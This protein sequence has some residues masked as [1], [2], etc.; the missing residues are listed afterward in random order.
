MRFIYDRQK[1][2]VVFKDKEYTYKEII[3]SLKYYAT[4][5]SLNEDDKVVVTME[6]RPEMIC[7]IF[8]VWENKGTTVVL[9]S[10]Y[11]AEQFAYAFQ[12]SKPKYIITSQKIVN[13]V[14]E[15]VEKSGLDIKIF[16]V[17]EITT[18]E[19]FEPNNYEV[20][21]ENLEKVA[22]LLYTSGTTGN[23]KG[24]MLTFNNLQSNINAVKEIELV[25]D[26]DRVLA[27]LP[28]HHILPLNLSM[29]MPVYFGTFLAILDELSSDALKSILKKQRISVIIGVPRVW[30][31]LHKGIMN[32]IN[33]NWAAKNLFTL[34]E[35]VG[36]EAFSKKVFK[37]VSDELGGNMRVLVS[38][39]A[40]LSPEIVRDFETL[41]LPIIEGYGLTE[42]SPIIAF[43]QPGKVR[44]GSVG[45][46][47]PNVE[48]KIGSDE[49]ILVKGANVMKGYYNNPKATSEAIDSD[50]WFHTGDLGKLEDNYLYIT[51]RKKEMIVL[52]NG[53][54][55][56][57]GDI[58]TE[59][60]KKTDLIKEIAVMEY[61]NHLMAI[62]YPD[63]DLLRQRKIANIKETLKWEIIDSYNVTAPAYRKIL[64]IKITKEELPKTKLGKIRRFMLKD[65]LKNMASDEEDKQT[66]K[67]KIEIPTE[68]RY[69]YDTLK[70]YLEKTYDVEVEPESHLELDLGLDSLD[71]VE[72]LS[73][74]EGN[75]G[76]KITEE[77]FSDLKNVLE[78]A[79]YIKE[80]GGSYHQEGTN[81]H[82]ILQE[83][84][85]VKL[86][87]SSV[88]SNVVKY[89]FKPVF[90][91][92]FHLKKEDL[93]KIPSKPAIY[94]GNHQ[95]FVD[96]FA[97]NE[98]I[99]TSK[100]K[101]T[102]YIAVATHF[103][104]PV[105]RYLANK[106]NVV[107]IDINKNLKD[108]LQISA[109]ILREGK[110]L[111]IFPEG[112]RTRDGELQ[113]FKKTF[114]ILSKE[115]NVPVV[116]FGIKGAY[117]AMPYG[118]KFPK[119]SPITVKFFDTIN[120]ENMTVEE[121]VKT[122]RETIKNWLD[123]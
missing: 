3:K 57:P 68:I 103:D 51:G 89:L 98:C 35:K 38:G 22:L 94:I 54:N 61:N 31:M 43:N 81:W 108:T 69:E 82:T 23:P 75:F 10:G 86:P 110:N 36:S 46:V 104:S 11:T 113:Q 97:F 106:G 14:K 49:E 115:L 40:K 66:E 50:G 15:A 70:S 118:S 117:E 87:T 55:I 45:Y 2:A 112:A 102:Y 28:F 77:K 27:L 41:G 83:D 25:N 52:S 100:L 105:R 78:I 44:V 92:Y 21:I 109:K 42:T 120:P 93:D 123:K 4:L 67:K 19:D 96:A 101:D 65:F 6:N 48:V 39:G 29:L 12:D 62:V 80:N 107:I 20:N 9:D 16:V 24:V 26:K 119:S 5:Y 53:K 116:P 8:S 7:S 32:K 58:E 1:T 63:F 114:A 79:K 56:N 84:V 122:S 33:S 18:P 121:I 76:V 13:T 99:P 73:F 17:D 71:I 74:I 60:L 95:S 72:I 91:L 90:S 111:V 47:I 59:I 88:V 64:E 85:D 34:C 37:K 30:E